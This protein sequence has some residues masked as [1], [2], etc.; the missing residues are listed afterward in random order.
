MILQKIQTHNPITGDLEDVNA[1]QDMRGNKPALTQYGYQE[2]PDYNAEY[3]WECYP[4]VYNLAEDAPYWRIRRT[5]TRFNKGDGKVIT[6]MVQFPNCNTG[7]SFAAS[8]I[9]D[10][11]YFY[12]PDFE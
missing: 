1:C 10:Y 4:L 11:N 5:E 12:T 9:E 8:L 6:T 2:L 3:K 7:Y